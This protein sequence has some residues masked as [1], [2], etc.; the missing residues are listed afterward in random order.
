MSTLTVP[1]LTAPPAGP[2]G[3]LVSI[4]K[5]WTVDEFHQIYSLPAFDSKKLVLLAGEILEMPNPNA[6]HDAGLGLAVAVLTA[7]F[8]SGF[9]VRGQMA[10]R[11]SQSTDPMPD[12]AVVPGSPRDY[13]QQPTTALLVVEVSDTSLGID[14]GVKAQ[15]YAVAGIA[16]Y[17]VVDLNNRLLL[18]LRDPQ[19]DPASPYGA[20]YRTVTSL[21][22]GQ[23]VS[24]LAAPQAVVAV[25]DL[26]P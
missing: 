12:V 20:S 5:R 4:R 26:L 25:T 3:P 10:L 14:I 9:W 23:S 16:D 24:P 1:G 13:P 21:T 7:A 8:G 2:S 15:L 19:A 6:P 11:L 22:A 17:W 18:V